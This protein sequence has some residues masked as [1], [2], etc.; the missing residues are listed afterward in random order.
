MLLYV[1]ISYMAFFVFLLI[2][3]I[4]STVFMPVMAEVGALAGPGADF[5]AEFDPATY[6]RLFFHAAVI[7]A[8]TSG[9][10]AGKIGG[11]NITAGLKHSAILMVF[12]YAVFAF[13]R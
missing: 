7:Q 8:V 12:A 11:G 9:L 1:V 3:W 4:L 13:I 2:V 6:T 10:I 5:L